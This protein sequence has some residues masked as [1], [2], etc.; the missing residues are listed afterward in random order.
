MRAQVVFYLPL[1]GL[2]Q[3][4]LYLSLKLYFESPGPHPPKHLELV[5]PRA[6]HKYTLFHALGGGVPIVLIAYVH[7][8]LSVFTTN[9][10]YLVRMTCGYWNEDS[11]THYKILERADELANT[12]TRT[13]HE[14]ICSITAKQRALYWLSLPGLACLT[15]M[16]GVSVIAH[17]AAVSHKLMHVLRSNRVPQ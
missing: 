2:A 9:I 8:I 14:V 4:A 12:T 3:W 17:I 15:K 7:I 10:R 6:A 5:K 13:Y 1:V 16:S 11:L